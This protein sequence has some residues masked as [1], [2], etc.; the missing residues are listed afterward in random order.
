MAFKLCWQSKQHLFPLKT[1]WEIFMSKTITQVFTAND[2]YAVTWCFQ[3][4]SLLFNI[5][6]W[7]FQITLSM[8][9]SSCKNCLLHDYLSWDRVG[10][11]AANIK[12]RKACSRLVSHCWTCPDS[13][14][15]SLPV[16]PLQRT[17]RRIS[18]LVLNLV[19]FSR[20]NILNSFVNM[21]LISFL[22]SYTNADLCI[23]PIFQIH[24]QG[25]KKSLA[26]LQS[27]VSTS[28]ID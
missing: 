28:K 14:Q 12:R 2:I 25:K 24:V 20:K 7:L 23:W 22:V 19:L 17:K 1:F 13:Q 26:I 11:H 16:V 10:T 4:C 6:A 5:T 9:L 15:S 18:L 8:Q 27:L 3:A 21:L